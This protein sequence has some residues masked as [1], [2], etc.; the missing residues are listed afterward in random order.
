MKK[1]IVVALSVG[2]LSN[3]IFNSGDAVDEDNFEPGH[4]DALVEQGFLKQ[5]SEIEEV[6]SPVG[7]GDTKDD[8][9]GPEITEPPIELV[10]IA[11][12]EIRN[13]DEDMTVKQLRE[14]LIK[15]NIS[16]KATATKAELY[17]LF[18]K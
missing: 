18:N 9:G 16:F 7:L 4:A 10:E 3:K 1:Y 11:E 2:G 13:G 14:E 12:E 15:R 17:E 8:I 6:I 5:I